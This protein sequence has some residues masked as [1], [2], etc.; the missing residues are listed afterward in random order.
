MPVSDLQT[1]ASKR[2]LL[3]GAT[4]TIGQ[5]TAKEL[6]ARGHDLVCFI[7]EG[8]DNPVIAELGTFATLRFGDVTDKV[9][10]AEQGFCDERFDAVISCLASRT[11]VAKDAWAVDYQA[12]MDALALAVD[13]DAKQFVLLSAI[14]VQKPKLAF[15]KAKLA[16]EDALISSAL[17]HSIVRPTAF[18]KSLSG[19]VERVKNGKAYMMFDDGELTAC[20]PISDGDLAAYIAD[21]LDRE[22]LKNQILPIGGPGPAITPKQQGDFLF[23]L[24]DQPPRMQRVPPSLLKWISRALAVMSKLYPPLAERA[25]YA[26]IGHYYATESMLML[27]QATGEY[28][29]DLTPS[30]GQ[31]TL[32][33]HYRDLLGK[34][35]NSG[36]T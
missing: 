30:T 8:S 6:K 11:G 15:Q 1:N 34:L 7:R 25:E 23:S 22:D 16:F 27:D 33:D 18:F 17:S 20:K 14:C 36:P 5:A 12:N 35:V 31:E 28:R 21:C 3:L 32:F 29:E 4:G 9:S 24:L 26:R 13:A 2:I 19:Q 10:L